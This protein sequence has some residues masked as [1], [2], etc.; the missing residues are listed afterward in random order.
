[1]M[2]GLSILLILLLSACGNAP[3]GVGISTTTAA[4]ST[5]TT[6]TTTTTTTTGATVTGSVGDGPVTGA[7]LTFIDAGGVTLTVTDNNTAT[8]GTT[9]TSTAV[10]KYSV[11]LPSSATFPVSVVATGGSDQTLVALGKTGAAAQPTVLLKSVVVDSNQAIANISPFTTLATETASQS[12]GGITATNVSKAI[13]SVRT[14]FDFGLSTI[15]AAFNPLTA[16]TSLTAL[17]SSANLAIL[18]QAN[19]AMGEVIARTLRS[20]GGLSTDVPTD[21]AKDLVDG[22]LDFKNSS[23]TA[24]VS[25]VLTNLVQ[26]R[27]QVAS[28]LYAKQTIALGGKLIDGSDAILTSLAATLVT[29]AKVVEPT[30]TVTAA[31]F[32]N[33]ATALKDSYTTAKTASVGSIKLASTSTT[34]QKAD[35]TGSYTAIVQVLDGKGRAMANQQVLF[36]VVSGSVGLVT[37]ASGSQSVT[38]AADG[39]VTTTLK[40]VSTGNDTVKI[41]ATVGGITTATPLSFSFTGTGTGA[42]G[43][44]VSGGN[45]ITLSA[46]ANNLPGDG[47][48]Q[49]IVTATLTDAARV[50]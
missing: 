45:I 8:S 2:R 41:N 15:S 12:S 26:V 47:Q 24:M 35:G 7:T 20:A 44:G 46:S 13:S 42:S 29:V 11:T 17:G 21:I 36:T 18:L 49:A 48:T 28:D 27:D 9:A 37:L 19:E 33:T 50:G 39:T 4:A 6:S 14:T 3:S 16:D 10:G 31:N 38:T 32:T 25:Q 22:T 30:T 5:T 1:M 23:G 34:G 43:G 40:D